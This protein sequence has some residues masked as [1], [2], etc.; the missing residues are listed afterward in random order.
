MQDKGTSEEGSETTPKPADPNP[1]PRE[2]K[3]LSPGLKRTADR[4]EWRRRL[5][6]NPAFLGA[7]ERSL[8]KKRKELDIC[9]QELEENPLDE[10]IKEKAAQLQHRVWLF[11]DTIHRV[12][13]G[14]YH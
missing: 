6:Q 4:I 7:V 10:E 3:V 14:T 12:K 13:E 8:A 1:G 2:Y 11:E 9:N 5:G